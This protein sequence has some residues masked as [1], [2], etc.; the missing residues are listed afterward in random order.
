MKLSPIEYKVHC[1]G[2]FLLL[3]VILVTNIKYK[4]KYKYKFLCL[5]VTVTHTEGVYT[6][7]NVLFT[8]QTN[9]VNVAFSSDQS[10]RDSGFTL[11]VTS[12]LCSQGKSKY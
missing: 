10:V 6:V 7:G 2:T 3:I 9:E 12:V 4:Y 5:T 11:D 1:D 8:S